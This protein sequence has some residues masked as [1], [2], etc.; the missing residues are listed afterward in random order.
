ME[1]AKSFTVAGTDWQDGFTVVGQP[2]DQHRPAG[3]NGK[4]SW[5]EIGWNWNDG[6]LQLHTWDGTQVLLGASFLDCCLL[7]NTWL[8]VILDII[9][10]SLG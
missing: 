1:R 9:F 4:I 3:S 10:Y 2:T 7:V 6:T 8:L 5:I